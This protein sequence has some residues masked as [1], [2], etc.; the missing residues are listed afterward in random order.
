MVAVIGF[1][2][3]TVSN[4]QPAN[5]NCATCHLALGIATLTKPA[6]DYKSDVH[7]AKDFGCAAC[8]GGDPNIMGLEAM[9]RKK[10]Y[11]G[12]PTP[13]QVVEVCG[14][15]H[16]DASFMRRYNPSLRVDQVA[17]YYTSVHG[18]RLKEQK[19]QKVA[20]CASCHTPHAI[21]PPNDSRSSVHPTRVANTCGS[22]HANADYMAPYKI[23]T[24]QLEQYQQSV[25]W[26]MIVNKS[27]LAAPTCNDCHGNH[28]AAPPGVSSVA[29]VCG[30]CH[31]V[32]AELFNKSAHSK[33]FAQMGISGCATCHSNHAIVMLG[34]IDRLK[35]G[36]EKALAV[37]TKA[38]HAGMEVSQPLFE[39]NEAKTTLIKARAII[40][41]FDQALL[42]KEV[43]PGL[44]AIEKAYLRGVKA[45]NE[46]QFR[47]K[48]LAV[49]ALI[50]F[51]LIIGLILKIRQME[52]KTR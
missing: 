8:H 17:E 22:C 12:K 27:D 4:A 47:R 24:D 18:K 44:Q 32:N 15:C 31:A 51:A 20:N 46:L 28:G 40:H 38:E 3:V 10:G 26:K 45:M 36:Y 29:N 2:T 5:D 19:D 1:V 35:A 6:E 39:L 43:E 11:I 7:A 21:R 33:I 34:S 50:I 16:S 42:D 41:G 52:R 25:H 14:K 23:P 13:V 37:L 30:Q 48:G 9:D 49:S